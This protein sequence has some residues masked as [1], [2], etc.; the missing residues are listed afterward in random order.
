M[1]IFEKL[2]KAKLALQSGGL[3]KSGRNDFAK[4][5]F[6]ELSDL[7]PT[8]IRLENEL[9]FFCQVMFDKDI[10][11]LKI[12]DAEKPE[13]VIIYTSPMSSASLKG[14]HE[15]QNLGAVQTYIKR[16]LYVNAFEIV[17]SDAVD[18][19]DKRAD[20]HEVATQKRGTTENVSAK[21]PK[22][23]KQVISRA[24]LEELTALAVNPDGK[25]NDG[26]VKILRDAYK[27]CGFDSAKDITTDKFQIIKE[28]T[29]KALLPF[30]L[31]D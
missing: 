16:Y 5:D 15:V 13:D 7:L 31:G 3:K 14:M 27:S 22:T 1:N 4:Y 29:E 10:A 20:T 11:T 8:I 12:S 30:E 26:V 24:Q 18:R 25:P 19:S 23:S 6:F 28:A 21:P 17:E 2:N 9:K